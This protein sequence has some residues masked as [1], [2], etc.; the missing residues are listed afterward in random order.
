[1]IGGSGFIGSHLVAR[2]V[3]EGRKVTVPTRRYIRARHLILLPTV[4]VIEAD[5]HDDAALAGLVQG[6]DA[7]V[8]LVGILHGDRGRPYGKAFRR[9][10]VEL[11]ERIARACAAHGVRRLL[12]MS[13]LGADPA[14]PSMYL[15]SK[16]DGEA[17]VRKVFD[18]WPDGALTIFRPSVVF[19]PEDQF[20]NRFAS[21]ARLLPVLPLAASSARL[22]P[23]YVG[24]VALATAHALDD[25]R[26]YG[27]SYALAG[28][29]SYTLGEL[30]ERAAAW[31]GHRRRVLP[32]PLALGKLQAGL[33]ELLPGEPP[34]SRDNLDSLSRDAV[35]DEPIAAEL[36]VPPTALEAI[37]PDYLGSM[38]TGTRYDLLR[39]RRT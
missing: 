20:M 11:P 31:S 2:L 18:A 38:R 23:V 13:A 14:G 17:A 32:L 34:L 27:R 26:T 15:R 1:M 6:Q 10:H 37:A 33:L 8:N 35:T 5:I 9:N 16:G 22:Q 28:P 19:G 39:S 21:L 25:P 30:V 4:D 29:Q 12:H 3:S 24:D 36:D 7:V